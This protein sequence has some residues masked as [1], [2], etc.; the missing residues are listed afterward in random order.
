MSFPAPGRSRRLLLG[1][2]VS[3]WRRSPRRVLQWLVACGLSALALV[4]VSARLDQAATTIADRSTRT[5]VVARH[6]LDVGHVMTAGDTEHRRVPIG[7][8]PDRA[9]DGDPEGRTVTA[10]IGSGE[11]VSSQRLAPEG[12]HGLAALVPDG[13]RAVAVPTDGTGLTLEIGDLVDVFDA[14]GPD[15]AIGSGDPEDGPRATAVGAIVIGVDDSAV[16]VAVDRE[17]VRAVAAALARGTPV[18]ALV[19]ANGAG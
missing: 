8:V 16:T 7:A 2:P 10:A 12:L 18:L 19:G 6:D 9:V 4:L 3:R 14:T 15:A 1:R 5:V 13:R 17:E 11:V